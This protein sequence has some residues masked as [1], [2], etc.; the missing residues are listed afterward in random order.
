MSGKEWPTFYPPMTY[1]GIL[2][3]SVAILVG[4]E[5]E[6]NRSLDSFEL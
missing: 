1:A 2:N 5:A 4:G 6:S 3:E